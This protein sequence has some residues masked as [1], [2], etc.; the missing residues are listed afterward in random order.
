MAE[1]DAITSTKIKSLENKIDEKDKQIVYLEQLYRDMKSNSD[2]EIC[3]L[4][5]LLF[6]KKIELEKLKIA[7]R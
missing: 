5:E 6:Q 3:S 1:L 2:S 7:S 4:K